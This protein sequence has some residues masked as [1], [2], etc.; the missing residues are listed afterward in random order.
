M[1]LVGILVPGRLPMLYCHIFGSLVCLD[2]CLL[3]F[4]VVPFAS[5]QSQALRYPQVCCTLSKFPAS[6]LRCGQW[7]LSLT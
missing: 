2:I 6:V 1:L 4:G 7:V 3:L 5:T